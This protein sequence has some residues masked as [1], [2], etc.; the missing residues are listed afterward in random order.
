[1][2]RLAVWFFNGFVCKIAPINIYFARLPLRL[3][4]EARRLTMNYL[5][6]GIDQFALTGLE[7]E[8]RE[9]IAHH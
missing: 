5:L 2:A 7:F 9:E 3:H 8:R 4:S 1:V 6:S